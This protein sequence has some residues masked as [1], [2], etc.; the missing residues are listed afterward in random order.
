MATPLTHKYIPRIEQTE[1]N[2]FMEEYYSSTDTKIYMDDIEQTEIAYLNYSLQEQ[3]KPLY[4]YSSRT[5]DDVAVGNR[6]VTGMFKVSIKNPEAQTPMAT[7]IERGYNKTLEGYNENQQELMDTVD[8]IKDQTK[9]TIKQEDDT[10]SEYYNK[11]I[12]M[13]T[14]FGTL[15]ELI[16][17]LQKSQ[18]DLEV[19]GILTIPTMNRIDE[20]LK[21]KNESLPTQYFPKGTK[22]FVSPVLGSSNETFLEGQTV[23]VLDDFYMRNWVNVMTKQGI[24]GYIYIDKE[25]ED[26]SPNYPGINK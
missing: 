21:Y 7:I 22:L 25:V 2:L 10:E 18:E 24:K 19:N 17:D 4:G 13:G 6:I 11:L 9:P 23:Y 26:D 3:L 14:N 15:E 5:F 1:E 8:W 12:L 16:K 20:L